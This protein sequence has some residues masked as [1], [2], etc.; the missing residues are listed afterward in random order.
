MADRF[1]PKRLLGGPFTF[2]WDLLLTGSLYWKL[3]KGNGKRRE[4]LWPS[5]CAR[6][7]PRRGR[8]KADTLRVS[9]VSNHKEK[10]CL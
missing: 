6:P 3:Y 4:A 8:A 1:Y 7:S 9:A 2:S 10:V 5:A